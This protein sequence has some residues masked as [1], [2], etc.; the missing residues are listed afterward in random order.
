MIKL[1]LLLRVFGSNLGQI[2]RKLVG[3]KI[4]YRVKSL[5]SPYASIRT[6][7]TGNIFYGNKIEIRPNTEITARNGKIVIGNNCFINR[8][9][10]IV[11]RDS[12]RIGDE[13]TIGPGT[14]IYDH[15]HNGNG[16]YATAPISIGDGAWLGAGVIILKGV[17]IGKKA[18]VAAGTIVT[19]DI[20]DGVTVYQKRENCVK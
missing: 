14:S 1:G 7:G 12:I 19:C 20:P 13:V 8:N 4:S 9:C 11:S 2:C 10:M 17:N 16:G 6:F 5:I 15:D 3:V 18:I